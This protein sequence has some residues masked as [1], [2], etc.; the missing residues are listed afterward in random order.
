MFKSACFFRIADGF[1]LPDLEVLEDGLQKARFVPCGA[2]E[3][4]SSGWV[5]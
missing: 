2:T 3:P 5:T 1:T 4:E